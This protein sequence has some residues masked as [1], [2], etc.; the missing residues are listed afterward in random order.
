MEKG[1]ERRIPRVKR[2][3]QGN[4]INVPQGYVDEVRYR[5]TVKSNPI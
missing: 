1:R 3:A 2:E 4:Y 5:T